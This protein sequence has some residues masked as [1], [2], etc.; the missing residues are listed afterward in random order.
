M[1]ALGAAFGAFNIVLQPFAEWGP[2]GLS[3]PIAAVSPL[4]AGVG[5]GVLLLVT[6]RALRRGGLVRREFLAVLGSAAALGCGVGSI[7]G[8]V[9]VAEHERAWL[10]EAINYCDAAR[11]EIEGYRRDLGVYPQS[12]DE[13][14]IAV[15]EPWLVRHGRV[16]FEAETYNYE[17]RISTTRGLTY[18][19]AWFD[20]AVGRWQYTDGLGR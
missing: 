5:V 10:A 13:L 17:I 16:S 19:G 1:H 12:L 20:A 7:G 14:V 6:V 3:L 15:P 18:T 9:Y 8:F 4:L 11:R 2:A